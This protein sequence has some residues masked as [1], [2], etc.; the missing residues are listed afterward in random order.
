MQFYVFIALLAADIASAFHGS[1]IR[2]AFEGNTQFGKNTRDDQR[3]H[4]HDALV[5]ACEGIG[6]QGS[7]PLSGGF[8]SEG[9]HFKYVCS[10]AHGDTSLPYTVRVDPWWSAQATYSSGC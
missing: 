10:C 4:V 6:A 9:Y 2:V 5:S 8:D 7:D 3:Q 1:P